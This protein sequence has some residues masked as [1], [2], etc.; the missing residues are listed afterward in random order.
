MKSLGVV[1]VAA[2]LVFIAG[3]IIKYLAISTAI[4]SAGVALFLR[5]SK[6]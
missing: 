3:I 6:P 5:P 1:L 2:I 4:L